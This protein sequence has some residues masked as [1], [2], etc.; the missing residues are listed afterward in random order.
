MR[1]DE[2]LGTLTDG[3]YK[4]EVQVLSKDKVEIER[5]TRV[6]CTGMIRKSGKTDLRKWYIF[7][8]IV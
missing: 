1:E 7:F 5:G 4:L 2:Q 8:V 3:E 6:T